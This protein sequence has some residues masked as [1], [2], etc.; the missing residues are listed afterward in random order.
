MLTFLASAWQGFKKAVAFLL[1][2]PTSVLR[3]VF[4]TVVLLAFL[5]GLYFLGRTEGIA[6][7]VPGR[8][9]GEVW[10][11]LFGL[12]L[13]L[14]GAVVGWLYKLWIAQEGSD[15]PDIDAAWQKAMK[16]LMQAGIRLP[17]TP[18]FL[19]LGR[20][21]SGEKNLF[22]AARLSLDVNQTPSD[23]LAPVHVFADRRAV[24]VTC[25][26]A[27]LLGRLAG[28]LA[29]EELPDTA[30]DEESQEADENLTKT[31]VPKTKRE[32]NILAM[33]PLSPQAASILER[34]AIRRSL[35]K[36]L[37][38]D[39][40][41]DRQTAARLNARL[42]H[43]CRLIV[44]DRQPY[45]G[46][47][48]ILILVPLGGTDTNR[49]A[50]QAGEACRQD[51]AVIRKH[52][53]LDCP[54]MSMLVDLE[55]F[56]GFAEYVRQNPRE[57]GRRFGQRFPMKTR[58]S[59]QELLEEVATSVRWLCT[60]YL[61]DSMYQHFRM[62]TTE[63]P[64]PAALVS[65]NASLFLLLDEM[66]RRAAELADIITHAIVL[67]GH[68]LLRYAGCYLA[69]TGKEHRGFVAAVLQRL[70]EEQSSVAWTPEALAQDARD[71]A[72]ALWCGVLA[73]LAVLGAV[74]ALVIG[75]FR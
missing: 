16:A 42:A 6:R 2:F 55:D 34:R 9:A 47:N 29:L 38:P 32:R 41:A 56:P 37:G 39:F 75:S 44:R 18:V 19:M 17:D 4:W 74:A 72:A 33:L 23:P 67:D 5:I 73:A 43:L 63:S 30:Q 25:R 59:E 58:L 35:G 46:I 26:G 15:F 40:L 45:C 13:V 48:G 22:E 7:F 27:S 28:I 71:G 20:P 66:T 11:P 68:T 31:V 12:L 49:D 57:L 36:E 8:I 51:L 50:Q 21:Q 70:S 60:R 64:E 61:Q 69:A 10:L 53:G 24:Y 62:E 14:M 3:W 65:A 1:P 54:V 52:V